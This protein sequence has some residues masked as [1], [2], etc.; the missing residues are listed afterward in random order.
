MANIVSARMSLYRDG[1]LVCEYD[2]SDIDL[3]ADEYVFK[4]P[5]GVRVETDKYSYSEVLTV[6]NEYGHILTVKQDSDG[7]ISIE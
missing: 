7:N 3:E 1:E 5:E 4:R 2:D 6:T